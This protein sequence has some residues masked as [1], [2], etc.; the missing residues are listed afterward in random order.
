MTEP[1]ASSPE[2]RS[3]GIYY[4][5]AKSEVVTCWLHCCDF[6]G[7]V[8]Y[9]ACYVS[10]C[11]HHVMSCHEYPSL[12]SI[13]MMQL[14]PLVMNGLAFST[15]GFSGRLLREVLYVSFVPPILLF[16]PSSHF[17]FFFS[18]CFYPFAF[19][20]LHFRFL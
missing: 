5:L 12:I 15:V 9:T 10:I 16:S 2:L 11:E 19:I 4:H 8:T 6:S 17:S 3:L 13:Q 20:I 18:S 1:Q 14:W 7:S